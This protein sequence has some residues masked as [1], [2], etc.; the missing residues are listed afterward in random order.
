MY[1]SLSGSSVHGIPQ[2][3]ILEWVAISFS[4]E[5]SR[6]G[7]SEVKNPPAMWETWVWSL[8][9]EDPLGEGNGTPLQYSCL[10]NSTEQPGGLE[11]RVSQ[12]SDM[13]ERLTNDAGTTIIL[14]QKRESEIWPLFIP[15]RF[16]RWLSGKESACQ[17][18]RHGFHPWVRKIPWRRKCQPTPVFLPGE[19]HGQRSLAGYSFHRVVK[20]WTWLSDWTHMHISYTKLTQKN[21]LITWP[22]KL[23][24]H[25]HT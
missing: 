10:E 2:A 22:S 11:F 3:R 16:P 9:M 1:C 5:S 4:R 14:M 23:K 18:R 25:M 13:T 21:K 8:D 12:E 17:C 19:F 7:G 6:P 15:Y 20:S 24:T